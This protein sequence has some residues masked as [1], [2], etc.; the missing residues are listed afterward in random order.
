MWRA[1]VRG[2][3]C[4]SSIPVLI[5]P[6]CCELDVIPGLVNTSCKRKLLPLA[7]RIEALNEQSGPSAQAASE[8]DSLRGFIYLQVLA[9]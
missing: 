9:H 6:E 8:V 7:A 4:L 1:Q 3:E 5:R 2:E